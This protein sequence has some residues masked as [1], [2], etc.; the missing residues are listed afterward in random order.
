M[1]NIVRS[2]VEIFEGGKGKE[3]LLAGAPCGIPFLLSIYGGVQV[4]I[5]P[6]RIDFLS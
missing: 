2:L 3:G 6:F 1:V 5:L 4:Y